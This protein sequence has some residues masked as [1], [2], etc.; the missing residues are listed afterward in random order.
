M[1][2]RD[3]Y[4]VHPGGGTLPE[5]LTRCGHRRMCSA[6]GVCRDMGQMVSYQ[7]EAGR[8]LGGRRG[9]SILVR[10]ERSWMGELGSVVLEGVCYSNLL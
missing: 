9:C 8:G 7:T 2:E 3:P 6:R 4:G 1:P 10:L 5:G